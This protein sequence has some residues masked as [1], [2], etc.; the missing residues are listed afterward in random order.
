MP[1]EFLQ[2]LTGGGF[3]AAVHRVTRTDA[4]N[5]RKSMP[6]LMRGRM[7]KTVDAGELLPSSGSPQGRRQGKVLSL[8]GAGMGQ[9]HAYLSNPPQNRA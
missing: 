9:L 3:K 7:W 4:A 5:P 1:G 6:L 2:L 8:H